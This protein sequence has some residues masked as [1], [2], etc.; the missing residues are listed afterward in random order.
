MATPT[1]DESLRSADNLQAIVGL[2]QGNDINDPEFKVTTSEV[3]VK[4]TTGNVLLAPVA[5]KVQL[6]PVLGDVELLPA[7]GDIVAAPVA[8]AI[9]MVSADGKSALM[10]AG[11][12]SL[13]TLVEVNDLVSGV[14]IYADATDA[15]GTGV[16]HMN[17]GTTGTIHLHSEMNAHDQEIKKLGLIPSQADSAASKSYVDSVAQ[18]LKPKEVVHL[19]TEIN[20]VGTY[21]NGTAGVGATLITTAVLNTVDGVTINASDD[22]KRFLFK[23]QTSKEENGIYELTAWANPN[24]TFTRTVDFDETNETEGAS[25]LATAGSVNAGNRFVCLTE[26]TTFGTDDI[27]WVGFAATPTSVTPGDGIDV[28]G[29]VVSVDPWDGSLTFT[30]GQVHVDTTVNYDGSTVPEWSGNHKFDGGNNFEAYPDAKLAMNLIPQNTGLSTA[31]FAA[32][33]TTLPNAQTTLDLHAHTS[34]TNADLA[35]VQ[36]EAEGGAGEIAISAESLK[37]GADANVGVTSTTANGT[38]DA[39]VSMSTNNTTST[40]DLELKSDSVTAFSSATLTADRVTIDASDSGEY[41]TLDVDDGV[42]NELAGTINQNTGSGGVITQTMSKLEQPN[43]VTYFF[44]H[45]G[46]SA[47]VNVHTMPADTA[48]FVELN[49]C[50]VGPGSI[51]CLVHRKWLFR[52]DGALILL[53]IAKLANGYRGSSSTD[54]NVRMDK[55]GPII[56]LNYIDTAGTANFVVELKIITVTE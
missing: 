42:I 51:E 37:I 23:E 17:A 40:A 8:G 53:P 22:G 46:G 25:V 18:G 41:I 43:I 50:A 35:K 2:Y 24:A 31:T 36:I 5:G 56:R 3:F 30:A 55:D 7:A 15:V 10:Q 4:N 47:D 26:V 20:I 28:A 21:N 44:S 1:V 39:V 16:I 29:A 19:A 11:T 9:E 38:S 48:A 13:N 12:T 54:L 52:T 32:E 45:T 27:V 34:D 14:L 49:A 6:A 33:S